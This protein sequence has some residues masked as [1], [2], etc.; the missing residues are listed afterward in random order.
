MAGAEISPTRV[1]DH[2]RGKN[3][4]QRMIHILLIH[5]ELK[6]TEIVLDFRCFLQGYVARILSESN[7]DSL[8]NYL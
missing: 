6:L 7:L 3:P 8:V 4:F 5:L 2:I 1:R